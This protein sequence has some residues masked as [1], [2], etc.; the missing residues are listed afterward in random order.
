MLNRFK[1]PKNEPYC[2][3][4]R[5]ED[6]GFFHVRLWEYGIDKKY[7]NLDKANQKARDLCR[8]YSTFAI[9]LGGNVLLNDDVYDTVA[10]LVG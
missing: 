1:L 4:V 10:E 5:K 9:G 3:I 7:V 6:D 2:V 8:D